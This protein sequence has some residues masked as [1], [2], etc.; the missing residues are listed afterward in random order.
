[1]TKL[2]TAKRSAVAPFRCL[3]ALPPGGSTK[4]GILAGCPSLDKGC[5]E[6]EIRFEP[7]TFWSPNNGGVHLPQ[8]T[9]YGNHVLCR[10]SKL[11]TPRSKQQHSSPALLIYYS[12]LTDLYKSNSIHYTIYMYIY[13]YMEIPLQ[14]DRNYPENELSLIPSTGSTCPSPHLTFTG[15]LPLI[16]KRLFPL[17]KTTLARW[18][19]WL[20]REFTDPK[21]RGSNPTAASRLP[22]SR[23]GQPGSIPALV[24]P[25]GGMA[26]GH[27]G[28]ATAERLCS[29]ISWT[30]TCHS[31]KKC[32]SERPQR[33]VGPIRQS[34]F[35]YCIKYK[36]VS[37][38]LEYRSN[39]NMRRPGA[40]HSVAWKH[41]KREIQLGSRIPPV[42]Q[43]CFTDDKAEWIRLY[44]QRLRFV[45]QGL[46]PRWVQLSKMSTQQLN[47]VLSKYTHLQ[48]NL[49][50]RQTHLEPS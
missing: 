43:D 2:L 9:T 12:V 26:A 3:A 4:A 5:R 15:F 7:R 23:L 35:T 40:A 34:R 38:Y 48:T 20:E 25:S 50:L 47:D 18:L 42:V 36:H 37:Q 30:M 33:E 27:R 44:A 41:H 32:L 19:K 10:S 21:V 31:S 39:W 28:G 1:V 14:I 49:V 22:L 16:I 17:T 45:Q 6:T 24:L 11:K 29:N 46:P 8:W 13:V